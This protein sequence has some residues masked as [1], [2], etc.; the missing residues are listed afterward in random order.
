MD[1]YTS[2]MPAYYAAYG[3][4]GGIGTGMLWVSSTV[5]VRK[6]YIGRDYAKMWGFAFMGGPLAQ[7]VLSLISKAVIPTDGWRFAWQMLGGIVLVAMLLAGFIA[8][9]NPEDYDVRP[10]GAMPGAAKE[11]YVWGVG[12]AFSRYAVWGVILT[13][14]GSLI[15]EF[16]VWSQ[17]V[18]FFVQDL[19]M[20][21]DKAVNLYSSIGLVGIF[22]MPIMG[23]VADKI[24]QRAGHEAKGRKI[25]LIIGPSVGVVACIMLLQTGESILLGLF[26]CFLFAIYWAMLPGG[27]VGYT[28]AVYGRKTLGKIWG[29]ATLICMGIGP[30]TGAFLGG[31]F[32]DLTGSYR[33]S[34]L[35]ALCSF[36]LSALAAS[37]LPLGATR[38]ARSELLSVSGQPRRIARRLLAWYDRNRRRLPWR[39]LPGERPDSYKVWLSEIMLQQTTVAAVE[40][41]FRAFLARWPSL[42]DLAVA[43]LDDVLHAWQGL[44][45]YARARNLHR[46]AKV[47]AAEHGGRLPET[48]ATLRQLPGIGAYTAAAIAAIA[49]GR[50]ATPVDGN[51]ER[52]VARLFAV[53]TP[54]PAAKP[55]LRRLAEGLTPSRRTGDFAQAMMDLG[56]TVCVVGR[57]KC[58]LC[59]LTADCMARAQDI[60][61]ELPARSPKRLRPLK[62]GVVFWIECADGAVLLR[63][64]PEK[65][66]LGGMM[67]FPST[68]WRK[69]TW[70]E[71]EARD[72][73]PLAARWRP[74]PGVVRHGFT[75]FE[76]ELRLLSGRAK[77]R[78]KGRWCAIDRLSELALPSVMKKVARHALGEIAKKQSPLRLKG[79]EKTIRSTRVVARKPR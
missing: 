44:G 25:S 16:L 36:A 70:S 61:A 69:E 32:R 62:H 78:G 51:V 59:P 48:E 39:A 52:V 72:R 50:K 29:L 34:I 71:A 66:L 77:A 1:E 43:D 49:F 24:V 73:A 35:F 37:S 3:I 76:L 10:F 53:R 11:E 8:K 18:S 57:P 27:V 19:G 74:I 21:L 64:R 9:K 41:Y 40:P 58:S 31:Y 7:V 47:V 42:S 4:L 22:S 45:Y 5:S 17:A 14:L 46:A 6:W 30:A 56:A 55:E 20:S 38:R 54:L 15:A 2:S 65:G 13:F 23:I 26:S 75:H 12:E 63:R 28:G 68:P 79:A 67:E 60:A 33:A